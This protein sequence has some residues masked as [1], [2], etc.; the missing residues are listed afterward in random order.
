MSNP[1]IEEIIEKFDL[2]MVR[3]MMVLMDWR[4]GYPGRFPTV[5]E[6]ADAAREQLENALAKGPGW[7]CSSGGLEASCYRDGKL[8]IK[9]VLCSA[10]QETEPNDRVKPEDPIVIRETPTSE[11]NTS[12]SEKSASF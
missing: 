8:S 11:E 5:H 6:I 12:D 2:N 9:S 3:K 4:W 7:T 1:D 10:H